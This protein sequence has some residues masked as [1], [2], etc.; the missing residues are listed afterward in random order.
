MIITAPCVVTL[1]WQ[2]SDSR[3][4]LIDELPEPVEFLFGGD[5]LLAKVES[6]LEGQ[7]AGFETELYLE[8]SDAFGDY[9]AALVCFEDRSL[10]PGDLEAGMAF[11][12]LPI[13]SRTPG[14]PADRLYVATEVYPTH[15]VLDGNHPLAGMALRLKLKVR[16]VREATDDE[17]A[18]RTVSDGL[19]SV[20]GSSPSAPDRLH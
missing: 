11:E 19:L 3:G 13:G 18:A 4:Q 17:V 9:D 10:F 5:D 6:A 7:D 12:G 8:P 16:D 2:L 20:L 15:V 1:S 14:M